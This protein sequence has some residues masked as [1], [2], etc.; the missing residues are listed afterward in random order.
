M[1]A[2][3]VTTIGRPHGQVATIHFADKRTL[4]FGVDNGVLLED[5]AT[6]HQVHQAYPLPVYLYHY[7]RL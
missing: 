5:T 1:F 6:G 3:S 4:C 7:A 2:S